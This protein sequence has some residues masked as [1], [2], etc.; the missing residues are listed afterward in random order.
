MSSKKYLKGDTKELSK[1][2]A[3]LN[4]ARFTT[5][6]F[7]PRSPTLN[8]LTKHCPRDLNAIIKRLKKL[9]NQKDAYKLKYKK[10]IGIV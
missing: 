7:K 2:K 6:L 9:T 8:R 5:V 1:S 10:K 3:L 4:Y